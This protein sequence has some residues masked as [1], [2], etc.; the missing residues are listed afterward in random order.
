M[1][2]L[3]RQFDAWWHKQN[4][5]RPLVH[6]VGLDT[7]KM[8]P[9]PA[10]ADHRDMH[11][12]GAWNARRERAIL[13]G[14]VHFGEAF[15]HVNLNMGPGSMACYLGSRPVY[16]RDTVWYEP[17]CKESLAELGELKFDSHN[18]WWV[19][20]LNEMR[21]LADG[22][23]GTECRPVIPDILENIDILSNL[24]GPQP[25][26]YDLMDEPELVKKYIAQVDD[27][28][29]QYYNGMYDICKNE[30]GGV[31]YTSFFICAPDKCAKIQCDFSALM[32]PAMFDDMVIPSLIRQT[33]EIPYT[34]YHLDGPDAIRHLKSIL[35]IPRLG[36]LQWVPGDGREDAAH[37]K[38][39][40]IHDAVKEAGKAL[41]FIFGADPGR[42]PADSIIEK[43]RRLVKRYGHE[44]VYMVYPGM[45][46]ND[47]QRVW[48]AAQQN[49]QA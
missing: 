35:K 49:F 24:R 18:P 12:G 29:M 10:P 20:H 44:G 17:I 47:A 42:N 25:L 3:E 7:A 4:E 21:A 36:A 8:E 45:A 33:E 38:W 41:W 23:K 31:A 22:L 11:I 2:H 40:F 13:P 32:S 16:A 6:I 19:E 43:S 27:L 5:K 37:P 46:L 30:T 14:L 34:L 48:E 9:Y 1:T 15:P 28:Y 39:D 26:C